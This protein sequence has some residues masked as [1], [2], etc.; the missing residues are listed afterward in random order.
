MRGS[1]QALVSKYLPQF[2]ELLRS[3]ETLLTAS[4]S[5]N[6][7]ISEM[8]G[9]T[10][11][12]GTLGV[13]NQRI[14]HISQMGPIGIELTGIISAS[15]KWIVLPGSSQLDLVA[16][17]SDGQQNTYSFYCGTGFSKD[18]LSILNK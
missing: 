7:N 2:R 10:A 17:E 16:K 11:G 5:I 1:N 13:T 18:V 4:A 15:K 8:Y 14:I 9:R 6:V 3:N 12:D